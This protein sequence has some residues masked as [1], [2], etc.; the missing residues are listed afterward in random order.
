M[1]VCV[2]EKYCNA[3]P[4]QVQS[5]SE[6]PFMYFLFKLLHV[7]QMHFK[8]VANV[9]QINLK[10]MSEVHYLIQLNIF[11]IGCLKKKEI[12]FLF[13]HSD[14]EILSVNMA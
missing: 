2:H 10:R 5:L 11:S 12:Y 1:C 13:T 4:I 6:N 8:T 3:F 9:F 7:F 14:I